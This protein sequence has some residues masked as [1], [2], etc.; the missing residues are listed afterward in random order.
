[1]LYVCIK[2]SMW[3]HLWRHQL[4]FLKL[5]HGKINVYDKIMIENQKKR[6]NIEMKEF[7]NINL[8]LI[9]SLGIEFTG[10]LM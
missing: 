3:P 9:D 10:E 6:E 2:Y 7:L 5:R 1:M 8:Y 4:L